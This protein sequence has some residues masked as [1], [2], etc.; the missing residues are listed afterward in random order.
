MSFC[1][2][3]SVSSLILSYSDPSVHIHCRC[4]GLMSHLSI[5][6]DTY[7]YYGTPLDERS[8]RCRGLYR[9]THNTL[10]RQISTPLAGFVP[11]I[12]TSERIKTHI[13]DGVATSFGK[14]TFSRF[15]N[16]SS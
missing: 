9:A 7:T 6:S 11:A 16:F 8:A 4:K 13:L 3:L 2:Y 5:L 1:I 15:I 12:P 10:K 14:I